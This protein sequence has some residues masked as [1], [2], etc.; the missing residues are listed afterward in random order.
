MLAGGAA[1]NPNRHKKRIILAGLA[2]LRDLMLNNIIFTCV[3][4]LVKE[5]SAIARGSLQNLEAD[6]TNRM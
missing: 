5:C 2:L 4:A 1:K 3:A 6:S